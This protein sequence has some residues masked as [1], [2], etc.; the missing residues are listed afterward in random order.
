MPWRWRNKKL[1]GGFN[2]GREEII[3]HQETVWLCDER[4]WDS[5]SLRRKVS[6]PLNQKKKKKKDNVQRLLTYFDST[7]EKR[8]NM[9]TFCFFYIFTCRLWFCIY[10][11]GEL[12]LVLETGI[13][14][15]FILIC[16][17]SNAFGDFP[18]VF[19]SSLETISEGQYFTWI[20]RIYT[21]VLIAMHWCDPALQVTPGFKKWN[22]AISLL[23]HVCSGITLASLECNNFKKCSEK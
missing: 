19:C 18:L 13:M 7:L 12:N 16:Y 10:Y 22:H 11:E 2:V 21:W 5:P 3:F 23:L 6:P 9:L 4:Y 8:V 1:W 15:L 17:Y 14:V 20:H